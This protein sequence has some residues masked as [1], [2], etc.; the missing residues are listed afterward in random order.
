MSCLSSLLTSSAIVYNIDYT[1]TTQSGQPIETLVRVKTIKCT[2]TDS[3]KKFW[4]LFDPGQIKTGQFKLFTVKSVEGN[5]VVEISGV[6]YRVT[7]VSPVT[8]GHCGTHALGY[9]SYLE[10]YKH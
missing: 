9:I 2:L 6:K 7:A 4:G 5:Q 3:L 8:P 10:L 1:E